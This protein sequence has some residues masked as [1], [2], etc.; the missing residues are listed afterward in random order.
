ME[1]IIIKTLTWDIFVIQFTSIVLLVTN[2][3]SMLEQNIRTS[4]HH[5]II[6]VLWYTNN[7]KPVAVL[8]Y[9]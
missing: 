9:K 4:E 7:W 3:T 6:W 5:F 1:H 8:N 2:A